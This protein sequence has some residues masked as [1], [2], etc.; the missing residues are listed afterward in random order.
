MAALTVAAI[1]M[2]VGAGVSAYGQYQ[3]GKAANALANYNANQ[4]E[5]NAAAKLRDTNIQAN[6][7]RQRNRQIM[8][9]QR[10]AYG[11]SGVE[12]STGSPLMQQVNAAANLEMGALE[13]ER[14][15]GIEAGKMLQQAAIDRIEGKN[16]LTA[17]R[18]GAAGTI[19]KGIGSI[20]SMGAGGGSGWT[21]SGA[22]QAGNAAGA[23][24]RGGLPV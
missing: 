24:A 14:D 19:I 17:S 11:A 20:A 23:A 7:V 12:I 3:A 13:A 9:K 22:R 2:A 4:N 8:G 16:Q 10:A 18:I 1:A 6:A 21:A 5:I 15:G